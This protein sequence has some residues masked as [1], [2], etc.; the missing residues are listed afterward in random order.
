MGRVVAFDSIH[1]PV[2]A[3]GG[4][5]KRD[6]ECCC[7]FFAEQPLSPTHGK[8]ELIHENALVKCHSLKSMDA[9]ILVPR[10]PS[11][12]VRATPARVPS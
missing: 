10:V 11:Q 4:E 6:A 12:V 9:I 3:R 1:S 5:V 7:V 2:L 8:S